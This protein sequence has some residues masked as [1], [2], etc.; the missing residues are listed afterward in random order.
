MVRYPFK[1][2]QT[3]IPP[4]GHIRLDALFDLPLRWNPVQVSCQQIF[5]Q[6]HRVDGRAAPYLR[7]YRCAVSSRTKVKSNVASSFR[8]KC[9]SGTKASIVTMCSFSCIPIPPLLFFHYIIVHAAGGLCQQP[10]ISASVMLAL[11]VP[12]RYAQERMGHATDNILKTVCQHTM[13][14]K[15]IAVAQK[16]DAYF[17]QKVYG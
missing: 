7:L 8:R 13:K 3:Q 9:P 1:Q 15:R 17:E 5:Y 12:N 2:I 10:H 14:G 4:Q 16:V 6:H 11:G